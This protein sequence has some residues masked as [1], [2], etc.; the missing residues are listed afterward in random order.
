MDLAGIDEEEADDITEDNEDATDPSEG[1]QK[2]QGG[3]SN[4]LA[5]E[6]DGIHP[7][8]GSCT[9]REINNH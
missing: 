3:D 9:E 5:G 6:M 7:K 4:K 2:Y 1:F 8:R